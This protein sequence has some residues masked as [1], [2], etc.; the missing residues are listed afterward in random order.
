[1]HH[2][3]HDSQAQ[4]LCLLSEREPRLQNNDRLE[5]YT[6]RAFQI[7]IYLQTHAVP[8]DND[9]TGLNVYKYSIL[10]IMFNM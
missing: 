7:G 6:Y 1:M 5:L 8:K 4:K 2:L 3:H 9:S 10:I